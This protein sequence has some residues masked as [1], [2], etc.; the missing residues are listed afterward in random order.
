M[1]KFSQKIRFILFN[2]LAALLL[3][4]GMGFYVLSRLDE[5][6]QHDFS[7]A[8]PDFSAITPEEATKV[9]TRYH[10]RISVID[11]LYDETAQSG[12]ILEQYPAA[13][14]R[15]KENRLIHL[16]INAR[17]PE[18]IAFPN[19]QNAAYRHTLQTL[20]ARGFKIGR[21]EYVPSEFKNLVLN[22]RSEG[23]YI[24]TGEMLPKGATIDILLGQ[25][26]GNNSVYVPQVRGK[27]LSEAIDLLR[28]A[29][30]NIGEI[31]SDGSVSNG[32]GKYA[33][34][35]YSQSPDGNTRVAGG[36]FVQLK[37][38]LEKNK[39]SALDTLSLPK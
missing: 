6:T 31:Y 2:L 12:T 20:Q 34:T 27:T 29:Y 10:L 13:G 5:Y 25:G 22:L 37:V 19:L 21:I 17:N 36:T 14:S 11:S 4:C 8:V 26:S 18:K 39:I 30:L 1:K 3:I 38:T 7:I 23:A 24:R 9:A 16:T 35:V 32:N 28:T 15:V 33:A